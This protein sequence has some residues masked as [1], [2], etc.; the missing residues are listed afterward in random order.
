M[1][2]IP[3]AA[4]GALVDGV[5]AAIASFYLPSEVFAIEEWIVLV[6]NFLVVVSITHLFFHFIEDLLLVG[7]MVLDWKP[8]VVIVGLVAIA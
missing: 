5:V 6:I 1:R 3:L 4:M 7:R 2:E 8:T